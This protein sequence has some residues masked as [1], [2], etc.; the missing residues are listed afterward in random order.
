MGKQIE[1]YLNNIINASP[2]LNS[3]LENIK[4]IT[5]SNQILLYKLEYHNYIEI[6]HVPKSS[7]LIFHIKHKINKITY[8]NNSNFFPDV[9]FLGLSL[10]NSDENVKKLINT[11]TQNY[12]DFHDDTPEILSMEYESNVDIKN[13]ALIPI[14][15]T[16]Q[17]IGL[18]CLVDNSSFDDAILKNLT[19]WLSLLQIIISQSISQSDIFIA[20]MSHEIRTPLNG[21]IGYNQLLLDTHLNKNQQ[22][23]AQNMNECS[24]QLMQI[25]NDILDFS[26]LNSGK[27][28]VNDEYFNIKELFNYLE[29]AIIHK[30]REKKQKLLF[31]KSSKFEQY[32]CA[33]KNKILQILMNLVSNA[34][35]YSS[36]E[37]N[38]RINVKIESNYIEISV[39]DTGVGIPESK[40]KE[41]FDFYV[42]IDNTTGAGLGLAISKK[43]VEILGGSISVESEFGKG[44][45][46]TFSFKYKNADSIN[47][48]LQTEATYYMK[49]K[50]V[51]IVDD[52]LDN[53][54]LLS[55]MLFE[56]NIN[57]IICASGIEAFKLI[58]GKRYKFDI[59]LID[60]CMP[61]MSGIE[62]AEKIKFE[63][64]DLPLIALSSL[65]SFVNT[66]NFVDVITKPY[67]K[68]TLF[69]SIQ[70]CMKI[71][72]TGQIIHADKEY[73]NS[74]ILIAEDISYNR[75]LLTN[76]LNKLG[77]TNIDIAEN[78]AEVID[79]LENSNIYDILLL[80]LK[81]PNKTGIDV[82]KYC[83][84]RKYKDLKI[85]VITASILENDREICIKYGINNFIHKPI[86][87]D[88][89]KKVLNNSY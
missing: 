1:N 35:K 46:F 29:S 49:G 4:E 11:K 39:T 22:V 10:N 70:S 18:L 3:L 42:Q 30:L 61:E 75:N 89:L 74:K 52:N 32:I 82:I 60:I 7:E 56:W 14:N 78:G 58:I 73:N 8:S 5:N 63:N 19:P 68:V 33:D 67:N 69:N 77:Y 71:K 17:D 66:T 84:E 20:N 57:P 59:A 44:S 65:D 51:L 26:K 45:T 85:I 2:D 72:Y 6:A 50:N 87:I 40:L 81:M 48:A 38:I 62:L 27:M 13:F 37:S 47:D 55:E 43:L 12:I 9:N 80:D 31:A 23:Y 36:V 21:I 88:E 64:T 83:K 16:H 76:I 54:I 28:K 15:N 25:I 41:I 34:N 53:R 24:L 79:K 86:N